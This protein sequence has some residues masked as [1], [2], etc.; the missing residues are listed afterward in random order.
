MR[1]PRM[2]ARSALLG[3]K[4]SSPERRPEFDLVGT[5]WTVVVRET[6]MGARVTYQSGSSPVGCISI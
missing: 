6:P 1:E 5:S 2:T 3:A 4:T